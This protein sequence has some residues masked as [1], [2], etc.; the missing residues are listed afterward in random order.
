VNCERGP[1]STAEVAEDAEREE[2]KEEKVEVEEWEGEEEETEWTL[3]LLS[4]SIF[5]A[6]SAPSAVD[7]PTLPPPGT[8][9]WPVTAAVISAVRRSWRRSM[10]RWAS[11]V[12]VSRC[13]VHSWR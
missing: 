9:I 2:E 6:L 8:S 13:A 11:R 7:F 10:A 5:S 1:E 4:L 12:R 3:P